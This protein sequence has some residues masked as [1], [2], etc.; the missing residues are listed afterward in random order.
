MR[1]LLAVII[2][3]VLAGP[4]LAQEQQPITQYGQE[5]KEKTEAQKQRDR[6]EQ[7]AYQRSL[8]NIPAKGNVDPWGG[9]RSDTPPQGAAKAPAKSAAKTA[10]PKAAKPPGSA[11]N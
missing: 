4:V 5:D 7:K 3:A 9:V 10:A 2:S 8:G 11:S 6:D 1:I